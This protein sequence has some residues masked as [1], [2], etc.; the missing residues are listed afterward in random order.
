MAKVITGTTSEQLQMESG[1]PVFSEK[2]YK[3][4]WKMIIEQLN[5]TFLN[6]K[7]YNEAGTIADTKTF[8][9]QSEQEIL[10]LEKYIS[11]FEESPDKNI[12][13]MVKMAVRKTKI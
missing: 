8:N 1:K 10:I 2:K 12:R 13:K 9:T 3:N 6:V 7:V 4:G 5:D 11:W